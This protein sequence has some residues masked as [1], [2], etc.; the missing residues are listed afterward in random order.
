MEKSAQA[1]L[2]REALAYSDAAFREDI[3]S[4]SNGGAVYSQHFVDSLTVHRD[5]AETTGHTR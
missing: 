4:A 5:H 1:T 2:S 3:G